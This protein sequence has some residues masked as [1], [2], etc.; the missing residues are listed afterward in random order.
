MKTNEI[1][2]AEKKLAEQSSRIRL[3]RRAQSVLNVQGLTSKEQHRTVWCGRGFKF[4]DFGTGDGGHV[5]VYRN[6]DRDGANFSGL[7]RCGN[8]HT[9]PECAPKIGERRRKQLSVASVNHC[10]D[11]SGGM[12]LVTLTS[13]HA[14]E[15]GDDS[16]ER[17]I[18]WMGK[19]DKARDKFRNSPK[20]KAFRKHAGNIKIR[21]KNKKTN[22]PEDVLDV[23]V[24]TSLEFTISVE[25]GW[26]PH[27]HMLVFCKKKG[28]GDDEKTITEE[29]G[30][31]SRDDVA[32]HMIAE[33]K[34]EWVNILF[35][36]GLGENSKLTDM[37]KRALNV[38]GGEKAAEYIAKMGREQVIFVDDEGNKTK[39][40]TLSREMACTHAKTGAAGVHWG[41]QHVTPFQLLAWTAK[42]KN[43]TDE[44]RTQRKWAYYRFKDYAAAVEGKQALR[45]TNGLKIAMGV[46]DVD[47]EKWAADDKPRPEQILVGRIK[48]ADFSKLLKKKHED[49][50][51]VYVAECCETQE[52]L[53]EYW[54]YLDKMPDEG[55]GAVI[56]K[57]KEGRA[58]AYS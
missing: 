52:H 4:G 10:K 38:R 26:H 53:D 24:V 14:A 25:N 34:K 6:P 41:Q 58:V 1:L 5:D 21:R 11:G 16:K 2:G 23:G 7:L 19:F 15:F 50:F 12:Y 31:Y 35:K 54:E 39:R 32:S 40:W 56:I 29:S 48:A 42:P 57:R 22:E 9:C 20:W 33:L 17:L 18:E 45:W 28:F 46:E 51:L 27:I 37:M 36:V 13:P 8:I 43:E 55:S 44:E 49:K 30:L 47:E 3:K